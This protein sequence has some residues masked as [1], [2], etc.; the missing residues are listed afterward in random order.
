MK[1]I[2]LKS[3]FPVLL[4]LFINHH[5]SLGQNTGAST[6]GKAIQGTYEFLS[7]VFDSTSSEKHKNVHAGKLTI[8][9]GKY[10]F[11]F[12]STC[13]RVP[14][15]ELPEF[16]FLRYHSGNYSFKYYKKGLSDASPVE[17]LED[18]DIIGTITLVSKEASA[19][20]GREVNQWFIRVD[21]SGGCFYFHA[22][23]SELSLWGIVKKI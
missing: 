11:K 10:S 6:V 2:L 23:I 14:G 12:D 18:H 3:L 5:H 19:I 13:F 7:D 16:Y 20:P 9:D 22:M 1:N 15:L 8:D 21:L 17:S 4:F